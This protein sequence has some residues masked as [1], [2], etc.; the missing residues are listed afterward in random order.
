MRFLL[1]GVLLAGVLAK[2]NE[3]AAD[4]LRGAK[5][6]YQAALSKTG[7]FEC[8]APEFDAVLRLFDAV[9]RATPSRREARDLAR[10]I[11]EK[12]AA[13][14]QHHSAVDRAAAQPVQNAVPD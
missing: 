14:M 11:R 6:A 9:P 1:A 2:R 7:D 4:Q 13:A 5:E 3:K 10:S 12:R 8:T